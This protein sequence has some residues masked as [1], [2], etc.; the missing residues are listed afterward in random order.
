MA[1]RPIPPP[2]PPPR[3]GKPDGGTG[4]T[5]GTGGAAGGA[6]ARTETADAASVAKARVTVAK[7]KDFMMAW[8]LPARASYK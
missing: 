5:A 7:R 8:T 6:W 4:E 1:R 2:G 3:R